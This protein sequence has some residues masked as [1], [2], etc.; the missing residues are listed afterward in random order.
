MQSLGALP[1]TPV[2]SALHTLVLLFPC[3]IEVETECQ[4]REMTAQGQTASN[5]NR[6]VLVLS[7][8]FPGAGGC[9][10]LMFKMIAGVMRVNLSDI[11]GL[12]TR[13]P[14]FVLL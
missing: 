1:H 5:W 4:K 2:C 6:R 14:R 12:N 7:Q 11:L 13:T 9:V 8:V 3:L 10:L